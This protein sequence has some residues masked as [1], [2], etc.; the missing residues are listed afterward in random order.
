MTISKFDEWVFG[1][2]HDGSR[3]YIIHTVFPRFIV[4]LDDTGEMI[5]STAV[6]WPVTRSL[7]M[8]TN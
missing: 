2:N 4:E 8:T 3:E 5:E 1:E 7:I 6:D